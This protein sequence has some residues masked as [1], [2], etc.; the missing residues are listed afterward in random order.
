MASPDLLWGGREIS[1]F[2]TSAH[3]LPP[4]TIEEMCDMTV[5]M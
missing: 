2:E 4:P 1:R 5:S 3:A